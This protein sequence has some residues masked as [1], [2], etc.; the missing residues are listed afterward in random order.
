MYPQ[1]IWKFLSVKYDGKLLLI[2]EFIDFF[3]LDFN[4][5]PELL[6]AMKQQQPVL[7]N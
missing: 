6:F 3:F 7:S 2:F 4:F 1:R 5:K